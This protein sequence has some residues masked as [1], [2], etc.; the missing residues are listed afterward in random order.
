[1]QEQVLKIITKLRKEEKKIAIITMFFS[2]ISIW[3]SHHFPRAFF[4]EY[5]NPKACT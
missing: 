2:D 3:K 1:M 4:I 5:V